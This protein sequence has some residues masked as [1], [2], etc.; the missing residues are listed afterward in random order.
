MNGG[1]EITKVDKPSCSLF[2]KLGGTDVL[3]NT[4]TDHRVTWTG[5][6]DFERLSVFLATKGW[7][8]ETGT[9]PSDGQPFEVLRSPFLLQR[10][11]D[12]KPL[13][14]RFVRHPKDRDRPSILDII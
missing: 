9:E 4:W 7:T 3:I 1:F 11:M 12:M 5:N 14:I 8:Y 13:R 6:A 10:K 2:G